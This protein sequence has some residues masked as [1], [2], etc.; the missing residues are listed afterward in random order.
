M[1]EEADQAI[2]REVIA[3]YKAGIKASLL[4]EYRCRTSGCLL[5]H[6]WQAPK[7]LE[8][9]VPKRRLSEG[10][11]FARDVEAKFLDAVFPLEAGRLSP[12]TLTRLQLMCDHTSDSVFDFEIWRDVVNQVPGRPVRVIWPRADTP[13]RDGTQ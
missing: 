1:S 10:Y 5:L 7:G 4:A 12:G 2:A 13:S 6:V 3:H 11:A 9:F 8:F